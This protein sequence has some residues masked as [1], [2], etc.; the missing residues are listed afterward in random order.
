M[1]W[2]GSAIIQNT[3][4][5]SVNSYFHFYFCQVCLCVGADAVLLRDQ[6][7]QLLHSDSLEVLAA[8]LPPLPHVL[9][10]LHVQHG[11]KQVRWLLMT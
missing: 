8:L 7:L 11:L 1:F 9:H 4:L 5:T 10:A 6:L 3:I 2:L